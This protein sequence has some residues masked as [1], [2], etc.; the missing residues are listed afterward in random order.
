MRIPGPLVLE[1][2]SDGELFVHDGIGSSSSP[3][4]IL[5]PDLSLLFV[6]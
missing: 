3:Q 5:D 4:S 6:L 1:V 2:E